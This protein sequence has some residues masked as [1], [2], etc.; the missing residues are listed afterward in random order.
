M[1]DNFAFTLDDRHEIF[2]MYESQCAR[3]VHFDLDNY[4]CPAFPRGIPEEILSAKQTHDNS[5][6]G[7]TGD[8]IFTEEISHNTLDG[9]LDTSKIYFSQCIRCKHFE[10][11][12]TACKA[13][14][15]GIPDEILYEGEAH[16]RIHPKQTGSTTFTRDF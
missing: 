11:D 16:D 7:Q 3:C 6:P 1:E 14:P 9:G 12:K 15:S 8:T 4:S 5:Y 2:N 13:F 10:I